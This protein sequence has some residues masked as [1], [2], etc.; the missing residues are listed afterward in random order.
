MRAKYI[1]AC[2]E[3]GTRNWPSSSSTWAFGGFI[4]KKAN[5][6]ELSGLWNQIKITL[7]GTADVELKWSH[8]FPGRHQNNNTNPL[9]S[10]NAGDW[11]K[12]LFSA[13]DTLC[14]LD[15]F[16]PVTIISRKNQ[17]E[18][19]N[20]ESYFEK[21]KKGN[22]LLQDDFLKV[23]IYGL[24]A[25]YLNQVR[26]KGE[27]W[28]DKL[29]SKKE[30]NRLQESWVQLRNNPVQKKN[31]PK[32]FRMTQRINETIKFLDSSQEPV[33]QIADFLSGVIWAAAEGDESF[34]A[35]FEQTYTHSPILGKSTLIKTP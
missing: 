17:I 22:L 18:Q 6:K 4:V 8:F 21:S 19:G 34:L 1:M 26:G 20:Y 28:M 25:L 7:C 24:F 23:G 12:E 10:N 33:I 30:Q 5:I 27:I 2:D 29:G 35:R 31:N 3:R 16:T 9:L 15:T 11:R 14:S 13:L 32:Y